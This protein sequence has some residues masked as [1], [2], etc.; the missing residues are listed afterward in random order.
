MSSEMYERMRS[1]PKFQK[2]VQVRGRFQWTLSIIV[3]V[4]FYGYFLVVAFA[5]GVLVKKITE[6]SMWPIGYTV[7]LF[8]FI[9]FWL[10][11][12]YYV[13]RSNSEFD[14]MRAD[15]INDAQMMEGK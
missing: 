7:E 11:T 4:M 2:L 13:I 10:T 14:E 5:P 1:N 8:L 15:L 3:L 6:G 9:F 12:L